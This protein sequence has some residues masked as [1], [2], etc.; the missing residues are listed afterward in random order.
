MAYTAVR[1]PATKDRTGVRTALTTGAVGIAV[2]TDGMNFTNAAAGGAS[3]IEPASGSSYS[4]GAS[5]P[6]LYTTGSGGT[7]IQLYF[8]GL[9]NQGTSGTFFSILPANLAETN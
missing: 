6:S 4:E 7:T 8:G 1:T 5:A 9:I 2:S 3:L